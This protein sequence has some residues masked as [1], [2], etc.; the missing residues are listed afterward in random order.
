MAYTEEREFTFRIQACI[1]FGE[2][3]EGEDD[4]YA[5]APELTQLMGQ[6][7]R[8]IV[9]TATAAGWRVR[10]ANRGRSTD[11]EVTLVLEQTRQ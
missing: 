3:Y 6:V 2:D 4:G 5:W 11:E 8:G 1:T 9:Q 10:P 7:M